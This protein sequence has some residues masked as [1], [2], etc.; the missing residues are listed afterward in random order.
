MQ[1]L[2]VLIGFAAN[3]EDAMRLFIFKDTKVGVPALLLVL[4]LSLLV[5]LALPATAKVTPIIDDQGD[6][7]GWQKCQAVEKTPGTS[8]LDDS[9]VG[10]SRFQDGVVLESVQFVG[11]PRCSVSGR[12]VCMLAKVKQLLAARLVLFSLGFRL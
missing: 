6:P 1:A 10:P 11:S 7:E 4:C 12:P 3:R 5:A 8:L 9:Y 2:Q